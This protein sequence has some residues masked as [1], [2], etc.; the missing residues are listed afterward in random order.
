MSV[1]VGPSSRR[2]SQCGH[3]W[4]DVFRSQADFDF[5]SYVVGP[6]DWL[7]VHTIVSSLC[8]TRS[9]TRLFNLCLFFFRLY[10]SLIAIL[11]TL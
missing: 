2:F 6:H 10:Q 8:R 11:A 5:S 4:S 3:L 9:A 1:H 7:R